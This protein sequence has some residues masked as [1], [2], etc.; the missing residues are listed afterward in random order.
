MQEGEDEPLQTRE[1]LLQ[2]RVP[3][4]RPDRGRRRPPLEQPAAH[5]DDLGLEQR[6][7]VLA[8]HVAVQRLDE[9]SAGQL[10]LAEVRA[11]ETRLELH[12]QLAH[13]TRDV[14]VDN[15][16]RLVAEQVLHAVVVPRA[17]LGQKG[18]Q[19]LRA[20]AA[21]ERRAHLRAEQLDRRTRQPD[22]DLIKVCLGISLRLKVGDPFGDLLGREPQRVAKAQEE[23]ARRPVE[24]SG[25]ALVGVAE[26]GDDLRLDSRVSTLE[27]HLA[28]LQ[29]G[30]V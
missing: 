23:A 3:R 14:D 28:Q 11:V 17:T 27:E 4:A 25:I 19:P 15:A 12:Q 30:K 24:C 6:C 1:P 9:H 5:L 16:Q 2:V 8:R 26:A 29:A 20:R 22:R 13:L 21:H 10:R 7:R 18:E